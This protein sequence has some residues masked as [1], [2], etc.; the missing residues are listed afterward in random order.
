MASSFARIARPFDRRE[1]AS[2][3]RAGCA[4]LFAAAPATRRRA[5]AG[6]RTRRRSGSTSRTA[7]SPTGR[8]S[9]GL[10]SW[11]GS[12]LHLPAATARARREDGLLGDEPPAARR[13]A[14]E[15]DG[16]GS[17]RRLGGPCLL[18][19]RRLVACATPWIALNE[20]WG[21]NLAAPW[22][23]TNTQY[24]QNVLIFVQRLSALGA[25]PFLLPQRRP[26]TDGEAGDWW[27]QVALYTNFVREI[28]FSAP[29]LSRAGPVL[30]SRT[31]RNC[32]SP[33]HHRSDLDRDPAV[34]DRD[35]PRLPHESGP[36]RPRQ[37][38]AR[39]RLVRHDQAAGARG[40]AGQPRDPA[41]DDLVLGLGRVGSGAIVIRTSPLP[42]AS[43]SGRATQPLRGS[44]MAGRKFDTSLT[45]GQLIFP[46][47]RS[48]RR[49]G[50][51]SAARSF[52][53][54]RT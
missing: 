4:A 35:L 13:R 26:F 16:S 47:G 21:S 9:R 31:L 40:Q 15:P 52:R 54:S 33:G 25:H 37:P 41:R 42:R 28:Y 50:A 3:R 19:R 51:G 45:E 39:E 53:A 7:R 6:S 27:R 48:A 30:A 12:E 2:R 17:D 18:P 23:P 43:Y 49:R 14:H 36:G 34:E 44:E 32:L 5:S 29:L 11:R 38:E 22:S 24:R 10:E 46:G 1:A 8:C 20:M